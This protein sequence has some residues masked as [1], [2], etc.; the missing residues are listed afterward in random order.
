MIRRTCLL[1]APALLAACG[2]SLLPKPAAAPVRY[3]LDDGL[4]TPPAVSSS[5]GPV[6]LLAAL[7]A[8]PGFDSPRMVYQRQA[9]VLES[10]ALSEW[11]DAPAQMLAPLLLRALQGSGAFAAVVQAPSAARAGWQLEVEL[12]RLQQ[13]FT[14]APSRTRLTLRA[15]LVD[16]PTRN[17]IAAREFDVSAASSSEDAAGGAAAAREATAQAVAALARFCAAQVKRPA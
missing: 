4:A 2:A 16:G 5:G 11:V 8:Q 10:F 6:L 17:V 14:Q 1:M 12:V 15:V 9:Q 3:T 13:D 7:R